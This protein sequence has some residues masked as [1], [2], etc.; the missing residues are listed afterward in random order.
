MTATRRVRLDWITREVR[1]TAVPRL[2]DSETVFHYSIPVIDE[3]GDGRL[4]PTA[5]L[6]SS[7]TRLAG[8]EVLISKLNPR[9]ARVL[10]AER[11]DVPTL[12]SGEFV[13]LRPTH[14]HPRFLYWLLSSDAIRQRLSA[15]VQSAT[16]SQQRVR[17]EEV[18]KMWV[19]IP[20]RH[21][22]SAIA[23]RLDLTTARL[24]GLIGARRHLLK[25]L[26][27]REQALVDNATRPSGDDDWVQLP[28][29][30]LLLKI[31]QGWSPQAE[32]RPAE[33]HEW[34]VL[35]AGAANGGVFRVAENK[36]LPSHVEPR[37]EYEIRAGDVLVS[38]ANTRELVASTCI[39]PEVRRQL[40]L[41]DKLFRLTPRSNVD[42]RYLAYALRSASSREAIE[43]EATGASDSMLN[44]GQDT[45]RELLIW[46][47][48]SHSVQTSISNRLDSA[49]SGL[50]GLRAVMNGHIALL[51]ER[52][53]ALITRAVMGE[54][55]IPGAGE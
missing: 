25:M 54:L 34:G 24:D 19:E 23:N 9:K 14:V 52:R 45:I 13:A 8:G 53:Y 29:K 4:E 33:D 31:E 32:A 36:A 40:L 47:P 44:V 27:A 22:Q 10:I 17:P 43:S 28:V 50:R 18:T 11:H 20:G 39:V 1:N 51:L 30:R 38:R 5:E 55:D 42:P 26:T 12:A 6:G 2:L 49:I 35:K 37:R 48:R 3:T 41:C 15:G 7:K 46:A 16:R 21:E